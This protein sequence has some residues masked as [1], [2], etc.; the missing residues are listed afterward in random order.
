MDVA[1]LNLSEKSRLITN[2]S[3]AHDCKSDTTN[4]DWSICRDGK[5]Y[6]Y[7]CR[8]HNKGLCW[9]NALVLHTNHILEVG[10][11]PVMFHP[12]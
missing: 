4:T 12:E 11:V 10:N 1:N 8:L 7:E 5:R 3:T 9:V 2:L 6:I